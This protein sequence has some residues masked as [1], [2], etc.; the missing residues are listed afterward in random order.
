MLTWYQ[1]TCDIVPQKDDQRMQNEFYL[2]RI[3]MQDPQKADLIRE[4]MRCSGKNF[5]ETM[6]EI[7]KQS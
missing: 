2:R 6:A 4:K 3:A 7:N 5:F 1:E